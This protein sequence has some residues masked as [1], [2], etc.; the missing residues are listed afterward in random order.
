[1]MMYMKDAETLKEGETLVVEEDNGEVLTYHRRE[2]METRPRS[3]L[4][5]SEDIVRTT[6]EWSVSLYTLNQRTKRCLRKFHIRRA[7]VYRDGQEPEGK[8]T[9]DTTKAW[10]YQV[11]M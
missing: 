5:P 2:V 9:L 10:R 8:Y 6:P 3:S 7:F 1:M 11:W 4:F